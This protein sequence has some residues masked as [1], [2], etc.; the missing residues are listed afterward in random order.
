MNKVEI[1]DINGSKIIVGGIYYISHNNYYLI[2]T[3][4]E[5]DNE[6]HVILYIL[7]ILQEVI[8]TENGPT[9][10]GYLIGTKIVDEN[11]YNLV[12]QDI[13]NIINEKQNNGTAN[14]RYLDL[15]MIKNL[16][17]SDYRIFKLNKDIYQNTFATNEMNVVNQND[18]VMDYQALYNEQMKKNEELQHKNQILMDRLNRIDAILKEN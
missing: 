11:E 1:M 14:V 10:T 16:K 2:Y 17:V 8:N 3:K 6:G 15:S 5:E 7:K 4:N 18:K 13:I 9:P 12:K